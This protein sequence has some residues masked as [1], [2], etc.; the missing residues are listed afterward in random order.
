MKILYIWHAAVEKN[1]RKL[2][3]RMADDHEVIIATS[4][5]WYESSK[6]QYLTYVPEIDSK[7]KIFKFFAIFHNHIRSFFYPNV[8]KMILVLLQKPDVIYLKE[9]PY[10][11]N[12]FQWV[13]LAKIFSKKSKIVIESDENLMVK[14]PF[15]FI[16]IEKFVLKNIDALACVPTKGI[17]LYKSKGFNKKIFKT[18]YFYNEE[19]FKPT[20]RELAFKQLEIEKQD[21][22]YIGYA[23]RITEEK[24]IEDLIK[25]FSIVSNENK[26]L[27]L[28]IAGK[29]TKEYEEKI[30]KITIENKIEDKVKFLG[31]L[32]I[33]KLVYFY[34]AIDVFVLPSHSTSWWIEQFGRVIVEAMACGTPVVGSS[35][36]E[37]PIVINNKELIYEEKNITE[38][39][40]IIRKFSTNEFSKEKFFNFAI[41]EAKK[42]SLEEVKKNKVNI[43]MEIVRD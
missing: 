37:I 31:S 9:E 2:L 38:L 8:F 10:S 5:R 27:N 17:E 40:N 33:E 42:Y 22:L 16:L 6:D 12:A 11:L 18:F 4:H 24:G 34:N 29:G 41:S 32:P 23:G 13:F 35:S 1:Y 26:K 43:M 25:A 39:A 19:I 7:L 36:G 30:K 21:G 28:L 14:H 3:A 15:I 20:D